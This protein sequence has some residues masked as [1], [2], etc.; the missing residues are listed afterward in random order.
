MVVRVPGL[1]PFRRNYERKSLGDK[2]FET[3]K[4]A[5]IRGDIQPE[6]RLVENRIA[7]TLRISRT[8]VREAIHKLEREGFLKKL[9]RGGFIV[10]GLTRQEI[11]ETF[12]IRCVLESYAAKLSAVEHE[13]KDLAALEE[14][15]DEYEMHLKKGTLDELTRINTEF[16]DLLYAL[17]RSPKLNKMINDLRDQ[18]YRFRQMILKDQ[19]LARVSNEDHKLMLDFIR[20][21]DADGVEKLVR[22]HILRGE[23]AVIRSFDEGRSE[24]RG[25]NEKGKHR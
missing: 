20:R 23:A 8:P 4:Q 6:N 11:K 10:L 19:D 2:V 25:S 15:I 9:P 22:E 14:K 24:S 1:K 17:S 18:I 12:G 21:R 13:G 3:L 5:I 16:H 7:D